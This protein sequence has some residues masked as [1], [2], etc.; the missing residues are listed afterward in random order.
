MREAYEKDSYQEARAEL[1][2]LKN[3]LSAN[4][5]QAANSLEEGLEETLTLHRLEVAQP[6]R[7]SL[8]TT[9]IIENFN[10]L[11]AERIRRIDRWTNSDQRHRWTAMAIKMEVPRL[12]GLAA[13]EHLL[14]LQESLRKCAKKPYADSG[15]SPGPSP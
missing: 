8:R 2:D 6:L 13:A 10:G 14:S 12:K 9:N 3:E 1:L 5:E 11:F 15:A 4:N 7:R